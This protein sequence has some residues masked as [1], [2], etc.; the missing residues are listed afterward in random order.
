MCIQDFEIGFKK[1]A[2]YN[3]QS[4]TF[5]QLYVDF[6]Q[7]MFENDSNSVAKDLKAFHK[8]YKD[9]SL[10]EIIEVIFDKWSQGLLEV[11]KI[12]NVFQSEIG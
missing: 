1:F 11:N 7:H 3:L 6:F 8:A 4:H 12:S 10:V 9:N 5:I 2:L